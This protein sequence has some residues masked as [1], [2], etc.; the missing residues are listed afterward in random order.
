MSQE[1]YKIKEVQLSQLKSDSPLEI[2]FCKMV[3]KTINELS[4]LDISRMLRQKIYLDIAVPLAWKKLLENPFCGE[5][6]E[7]QMLEI[8]TRVLN[9]SVQEKDDASYNI[10]IAGIKEKIERH[11][12]ESNE[13]KK[14]MR[15]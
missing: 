4:L 10:F 14:N 3:Q 5:L 11:E 7:G 6:Y 1:I 13:D 2:W 8:L 9:D 15:S 12:W